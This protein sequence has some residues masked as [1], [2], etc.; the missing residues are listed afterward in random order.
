MNAAAA[1]PIARR[2]PVSEP[3]ATRK[4]IQFVQR[5]WPTILFP[6]KINYFPT[7]QIAEHTDAEAV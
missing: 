7:V 5:F 4:Q 3:R 2:L 1:V 6:G